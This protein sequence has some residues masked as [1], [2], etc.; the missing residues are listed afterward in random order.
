MASL[1]QLTGTR[2]LFG[3]DAGEFAQRARVQAIARYGIDVHIGVADT[4]STAAT[5][6]ARTGPAGVLHLPDHRAV[7]AF[8]SPLPV[9][10]VHGIGPAQ[11]SALQRYGL[12]TVAALAAMD[13]T[14]VCRILGGKAGRTLQARAG[15]IDPRGVTA[16][17]LPE[18]TSASHAFTVDTIDPVRV[19]AALLD[20]VVTL[21]GRIRGR[22]QVTRA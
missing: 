4:W 6:S 14:V 21:A 9:Q 2:R 19:R 13:E 16:S 11:A 15:G 5:A 20:L 12:H 17:R 18:S 3:V 10:A 22:E 1:A 8:L 7:E